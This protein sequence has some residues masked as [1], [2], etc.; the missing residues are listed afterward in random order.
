MMAKNVSKN[1]GR[2]VEIGAIIS[3]AFASRCPKAA[4]SSLPE[5]TN[6]HHAGK[7]LYLGL[8]V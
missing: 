1:P 3:S 8:S 6:F 7:G 2:A 5:V 4:L